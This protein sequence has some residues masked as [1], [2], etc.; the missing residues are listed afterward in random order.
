MFGKSKKKNTDEKSTA[1]LTE[2]A[3]QRERFDT[4]I[5][6][7]EESG[8][9]ISADIAQVVENTD[10][11]VENAQFN[12]QEEG[13]LLQSIDTAARE[14]DACVKESSLLQQM[15]AEQFE[16]IRALVEENKHYTTPAKYLTEF[17]AG[18]R[19]ELQSVLGKTEDE[20]LKQELQSV[21]NRVDK[22]EEVINHLIALIKENNVSTTHLLKK[23]QKAK[24]LVSQTVVKDFTE[25]FAQIRDKAVGLQNLDE[26]ILKCGE[27]N[28]IQLADITEDMQSQK[29]E[30]AEMESDVSYVYDK[31]FTQNLTQIPN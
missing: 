1:L 31:V 15:V 9:R 16:D 28:K 29:R 14:V 17:P 8:K 26:E 20:Q 11:L 10:S 3:E 5:A 22:A 13:V 18:M 19:T 27:R 21:V 2:M 30:L 7:I 25:D 12:V 4:G 6:Q 23:S 24:N